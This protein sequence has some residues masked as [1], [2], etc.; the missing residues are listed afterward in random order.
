M[1]SFFVKIFPF[2]KG[3]FS[4]FPVGIIEFPLFF[5]ITGETPA[6]ALPP[7]S[8]PAQNPDKYFRS[9][10]KTPCLLSADTPKKTRGTIPLNRFL[11]KKKRALKAILDPQKYAKQ[12]CKL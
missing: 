11:T 5:F 7:R 4:I 9:G 3:Y 6:A 2:L 10:R 8:L 1:S 12:P